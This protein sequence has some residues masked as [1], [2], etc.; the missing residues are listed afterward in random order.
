MTVWKR[1]TAAFVM[2]VIIIGVLA[3][4][5]M[6]LPANIGDFIISPPFVGVT[7]G[8]SFLVAPYV[9]KYIKVE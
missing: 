2:T 6:F 8:I 5:D 1:A 4:I 3:I 9:T 7:F